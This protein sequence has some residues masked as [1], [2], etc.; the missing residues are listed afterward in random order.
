MVSEKAGTNPS[1]CPTVTP[2]CF[3]LLNVKDDW[4]KSL[5]PRQQDWE[6]REGGSIKEE[7]SIKSSIVQSGDQDPSSCLRT[8]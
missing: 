2:L 3:S 4:Q 7:V 5:F 6:E 8:E 1:V